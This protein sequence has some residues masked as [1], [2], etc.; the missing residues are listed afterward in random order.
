MRG[1]AAEAAWL[2]ALIASLTPEQ[3]ATLVSQHPQLIMGRG[4][5]G[6]GER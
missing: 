2:E 1:W 6:A 4:S 3:L 5:V